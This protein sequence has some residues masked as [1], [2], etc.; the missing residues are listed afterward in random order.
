MI[1]NQTNIIDGLSKIVDQMVK[2][3]AE[4]RLGFFNNIIWCLLVINKKSGPNMVK[5]EGHVNITQEQKMKILY[6]IS[7]YID[8]ET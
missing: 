3:N 1:L 6:I 2:E 4:I 5:E 8:L 7:T